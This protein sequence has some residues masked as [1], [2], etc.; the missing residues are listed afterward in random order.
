MDLESVSGRRPLSDGE[1]TLEVLNR[2]D[3]C[4]KLPEVPERLQH[5]LSKRSY[6]KALAWFEDPKSPHH[7]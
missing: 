3:A 1:T 7:P 2:L 4:S 5:Y 6:V